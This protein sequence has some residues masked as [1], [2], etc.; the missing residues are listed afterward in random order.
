M[1]DFSV[2]SA[3]FD[4]LSDEE[5]YHKFTSEFKAKASYENENSILNGKNNFEGE[6]LIPCQ[7]CTNI[8]P[9][10]DN[11]GNKVFVTKMRVELASDQMTD[12]PS[13]ISDPA[14]RQHYI[15]QHQTA[16]ITV[17]ANII[18]LPK[19]GDKVD[20]FYQ[21][22]GPNDQGKLRGLRFRPDVTSGQFPL[23]GAFGGA[24]GLFGNGGLVGVGQLAL[25]SAPNFSPENY[26]VP[27]EEFLKRVYE[28]FGKT[29]ETLPVGDFR[30]LSIR[31]P[32]KQSNLNSYSDVLNIFEMTATGMK[33][34]IFPFTTVPGGLLF[35]EESYTKKGTSIPQSGFYEDYWSFHTHGAK[36]QWPKKGYLAGGQRGAINFV[37]DNNRNGIPDPEAGDGNINLYALY[38][39]SPGFNFHKAGAKSSK[40]TPVSSASKG[41]KAKTF[42][43]INGKVTKRITGISTW[44]GG[45]QVMPVKEQFESITA[46][47]EAN[48]QVNRRGTSKLV[49]SVTGRVVHEKMPR[50]TR[51]DYIM[52]DYDEYVELAQGKLIDGKGKMESRRQQVAAHKTFYDQATAKINANYVNLT[53][54]KE[55][56]GS[57]STV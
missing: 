48:Y 9:L 30:M 16:Y 2:Y 19:P 55:D 26:Q 44:S 4:S 17:D 20:C 7:E 3:F 15:D 53:G 38:S 47:M 41:G 56:G 51:Y 45:C 29:Y 50:E 14:K 37:H 23:T 33:V 21:A 39:A 52:L 22:A 46:K 5:S 11:M 32:I 34:S 10:S 40:D 42:S 49:D 13:T 35:G 1:P 43:V 31:F 8:T 6:V 54:Q 27:D 18:A 25:E 57:Q 28:S 24:A 12:H 36:G